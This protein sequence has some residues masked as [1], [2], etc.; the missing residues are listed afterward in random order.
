MNY[1][2]RKKPGDT[3]NYNSSLVTIITQQSRVHSN[4]T[5]AKKK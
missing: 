5:L 1:T 2:N 4:L 3:I